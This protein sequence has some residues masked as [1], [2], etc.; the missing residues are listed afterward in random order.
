MRPSA[1][2]PKTFAYK[3]FDYPPP[4]RTERREEKSE[5]RVEDR[6]NAKKLRS[7]LLM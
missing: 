6:R 1:E 7:S 3:E 4:P 2:A 5:E